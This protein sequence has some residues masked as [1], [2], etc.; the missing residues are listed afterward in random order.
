VRAAMHLPAACTMFIP[1]SPLF[2]LSHRSRRAAHRRRCARRPAARARRVA[3][4]VGAASGG[5]RAL[6][7][8][9]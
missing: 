3:R 6:A 8:G 4:R 1:C 2:S 5:R 7:A 9:L